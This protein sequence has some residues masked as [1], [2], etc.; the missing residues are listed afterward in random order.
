MK[1]RKEG[2]EGKEDKETED[3]RI[4]DYLDGR[5]EEVAAGDDQELEIY[6]SLYQSLST[7]PPPLPENFSDSVMDTIHK[8]QQPQASHEWL[9]VFGVSILSA[10]VTGLV[11]WPYVESGLS[12]DFQSLQNGL[13]LI[14][15]SAQSIAVWLMDFKYFLQAAAVLVIVYWIDRRLNSYRATHTTHT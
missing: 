8:R 10:I 4:Q 13:A 14:K 15:S 2:K 5:K 1:E 11:L 12:T 9:W 3:I 7:P 6:R